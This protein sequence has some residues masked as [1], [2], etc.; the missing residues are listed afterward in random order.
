DLPG[1]ADPGGVVRIYRAILPVGS[2][3]CPSCPQCLGLVGRITVE[4]TAKTPD[5]RRLRFVDDGVAAGNRYRYRLLLC[6]ARGQ[7]G[8]AVDSSEISIP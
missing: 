2:K 3:D 8:D 7:C 5:A 1:G 4:S 6:G